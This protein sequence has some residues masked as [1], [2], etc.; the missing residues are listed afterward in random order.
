MFKYLQ[1]VFYRF[2]EDST[3]LAK[4]GV[5]FFCNS[6]KTFDKDVVLFDGFCGCGV[7]GIEFLLSCEGK[8]R[9]QQG[10]F[11][12]K[13]PNMIPFCEKNLEQLRGKLKGNIPLELY[14]EDFFKFIF[15]KKI[16]ASKIFFLINPPYFKENIQRQ[17]ENE[18][19]KKARFF[20]QE[21]SL[22]KI[23]LKI[24]EISISKKT[25]GIVLYRVD[26]EDEEFLPNLR[27]KLR[28]INIFVE[29]NVSKKLVD[30]IY[31]KS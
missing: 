9:I 15:E 2:S 28:N 31:F 11:L 16:F 12:E 5:Q 8:K 19:R 6:L 10:V 18:D 4:K 13:N 1:P 24:D 20:G 21:E 30:L 27:K 23:F 17:P 14:N 3:F 22:E 29:E 25:A 26:Q 7:V